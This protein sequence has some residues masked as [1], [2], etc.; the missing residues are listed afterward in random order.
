MP[1]PTLHKSMR[2][3][4]LFTKAPQQLKNQIFNDNAAISQP[5]SVFQMP[6]GRALYDPKGRV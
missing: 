4:Q 1:Q 2:N 5:I 3:I 6:K